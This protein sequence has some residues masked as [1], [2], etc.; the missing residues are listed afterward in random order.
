MY[1]SSSLHKCTVEPEI[2]ICVCLHAGALS[3]FLCVQIVIVQL[4]LSC[5]C[6]GLGINTVSLIMLSQVVRCPVSL[7]LASLF[8]VRLSV[9]SS[10]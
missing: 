4:I 6:V 3:L 5:V 7:P 8:L 2:S 10:P 1:S 9:S